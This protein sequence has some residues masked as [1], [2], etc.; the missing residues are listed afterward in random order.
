MNGF[1]IIIFIQSVSDDD[2]YVLL[3]KEQTPQDRSSLPK[4]KVRTLGYLSR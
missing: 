1:T 4:Q 3:C 2:G